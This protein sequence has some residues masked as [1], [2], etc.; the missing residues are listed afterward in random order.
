MQSNNKKKICIVVVSLGQGGAE[1]STSLL[2][3]ALNSLNYDVHLV[4]FL[5]T[6][7][8]DYEG[9]LFNLGLL[10]E[11]DNSLYG[12]ISRFLE[13]KKYLQKH[14]FDV[15]IDSRTRPAILREIFISKVVY[16][17]FKVVY[18]VRSFKLDRYFVP[19][20]WLAKYLYNS[21]YKIVTVSKELKKAVEHKYGFNNV[22]CIYNPIEI[23]QES[24]RNENPVNSRY[25]LYFGRLVD[26]V[27]NLKLLINAYRIS[28]LHQENI[29][30]VILGSGSDE[31]MLKT[32]VRDCEMDTHVIFKGFVKNPNCYIYNALF[33]VLTSRYEGFPRTLIESLAQGTPVISVDCSSGPKEIVQNE[34]NGLLIKNNDET[35][36]A[37]AFNRFIFDVELLERCRNNAKDS[38]KHL[39]ISKI[40]KEWQNII[41]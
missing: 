29:K 24:P 27:K 25:I 23:S 35:E 34:L 28:K 18:I 8:Y 5:N 38:V 7:D 17:S 13:L 14:N 4:T 1:R 32:Y 16:R 37:N 31:D 9:E 3:K 21:A 26:E 33:T 11:K 15:V 2:T 20:N 41:K 39:S 19:V 6:I 22:H 36:L 30:L 12:K 40:A 10:R